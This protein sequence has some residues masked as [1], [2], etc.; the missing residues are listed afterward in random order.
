[1]PKIKYKDFKFQPGSLRL[2]N[3]CN[4]IIADY[5]RDNLRLTLRQLYYVLVTLGLDQGGIANKVSEYKRLGSIVNDGRLAGLIDWDAI[6]DRTRGL[7]SV[8]HWTNPDDIIRSAAKSFRIDKWA[9]QPTR[10]EVWIEKEA[11]AGVFDQICRTL[12]VSYLSCRGYT[13]QSE[14][15]SGAMR[16][17]RYIKAGQ[18]IH[19]L[20]FGDHD[21]SGIDMTRDIQDR[22]R[23]F[24]SHHVGKR[25]A[26]W[27]SLTRV[28]L[29]MNQV[30]QYEPPENP[31]K[32]TDSRFRSYEE[33]F[34]E[35]SWELDAL[36]PRIL[37]ALVRTQVEASRD[38]TL[39]EAQVDRE[40]CD[41]ALLSVT[42]EHWGDVERWA[43]DQW[44]GEIEEAIEE[45]E[46]SN[47]IEEEPETEEDSEEN[48]E[49]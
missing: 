46:N 44:H 39:W 16:F 24:I 34:G 20:H 43:D 11:L 18:R 6:E 40:N 4:Q 21:P 10:V 19:V 27:F 25:L 47:G 1:M 28:A 48:E 36:N 29:N 22:L 9:D 14:M 45:Q 5:Q 38:N 8:S 17:V 42:S 15:W 35:S 13:S 37:R 49:E 23:M 3:R 31:A 7:E 12:D 32:T 26:N 41:R 2:I 30:R 33:E